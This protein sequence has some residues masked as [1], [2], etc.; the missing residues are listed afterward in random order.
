MSECHTCKRFSD[1]SKGLTLLEWRGSELVGSKHERTDSS[2]RTDV[3]TLVTL[4]TVLC[5]PFGNE[6]RNT[7]LL[8]FGSTILPNAVGVLGECRNR[9]KVAV[10]SV[11]RTDDVLDKFRS[12][13]GSSLADFKI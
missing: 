4:D 3:G 5:I 13:V 7:A 2:V 11:D 6:C 12:I 1:S 8:I 10:L 9:E